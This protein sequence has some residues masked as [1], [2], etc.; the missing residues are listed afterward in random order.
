M[1]DFAIQQEWDET[2]RTK[3]QRFWCAHKRV[4]DLAKDLA[5]LQKLYNDT[6]WEEYNSLH[7]LA[8]TNAFHHLEPRI[9]HDAPTTSDI[10]QAMLNAGYCKR[11]K[12]SKVS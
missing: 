4:A 8:C 3:V 10:P 12:L 7:T 9:L 1:V 11:Y 6:Q 5:N 2:F